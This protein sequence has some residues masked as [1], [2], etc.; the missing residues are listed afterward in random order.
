MPA[1]VNIRDPD[2]DVG[3]HVTENGELVVAP[4]RYSD[5]YQAASP[6]T[7]PTNVVSG[8]AGKSFV[9]TSAIIAQDKQNVDVDITVY[10][11][12]S[13]IATSTKTLFSGSTTKSDRIVIPFLNVITSPTKWINFVQDSTT[14]TISVTITGYYVDTP[15]E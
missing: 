10:E 8:L 2:N 4:L 1:P 5:V 11:S 9:I 13:T 7:T 12:D 3:A 14:A 6:D 15:T